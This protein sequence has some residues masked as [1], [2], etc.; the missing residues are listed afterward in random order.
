MKTIRDLQR[1][2][3]TVRPVKTI[4]DLYRLVETVRPA[5]TIKTYSDW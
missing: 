1:L 3:E 5:K 2:V 4:G